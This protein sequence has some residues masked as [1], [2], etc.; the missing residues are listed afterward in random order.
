MTAA[1]PEAIPKQTAS[2]TV[3]SRARPSAMPATMLSPAPTLL[4]TGTVGAQNPLTPR[5]RHQKRSGRSHGYDND[6]RLGVLHNLHGGF[7]L[8]LFLDQFASDQRA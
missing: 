5:R 2:R 1:A 7:F 4:L 8:F 6:L 3:M